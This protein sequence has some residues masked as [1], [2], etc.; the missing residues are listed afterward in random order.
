MQMCW[1]PI[2]C[3]GDA[4]WKRAKSWPESPG[5]SCPVGT[6]TI[7]WQGDATGAGTTISGAT[8]LNNTITVNNI[9]FTGTVD[10]SA[11]LTISTCTFADVLTCGYGT[12]L[13]WTN[14]TV[15]KKIVTNNGADLTWDNCNTSGTAKL[16]IQLGSKN[17]IQNSTV[18]VGNDPT[19]ITNISSTI[20]TGYTM[21]VATSA[22]GGDDTVADGLEM[23]SGSAT[24]TTANKLVD[25]GAN[26][27]S[28]M[29]NKTV[30][31]STNDTWAKITA[32][33]S[34]TQLSLSVDIMTSGD[35]Y[36]VA[37]AFSTRQAAINAIPGS[38]NANT[39][40]KISS[41][42]W[43]E[44][45][46]LIQ[47]KKATGTFGITIKGTLPTPDDTGTVTSVNG[48]SMGA[49]GSGAIQAAISDSTKAWTTNQHQ[50]K[51]LVLTGGTGA[52]DEYIIDSSTATVLTIAGVWYTQ[53]DTT[54]TYAIY[55]LGL[56]TNLDLSSL[57]GLE[58]HFELNGQIGVTLRHLKFKDWHGLYSVY[59][60]DFS[61]ISIYGCSF[62]RGRTDAGSDA[63]LQVESYATLPVID[64]TVF[65][66]TGGAVTRAI[67][68]QQAGAAIQG[69]NMHNIKTWGFIDSIVIAASSFQNWSPSGHGWVIRNPSAHGLNL[70]SFSRADLVSCILTGAGTNN[71][72]VADF[73]MLIL[74]T[75]CEISSA[76]SDGII[77]NGYGDLVNFWT[78]T[79]INSN[80]GWGINATNHSF[81]KNV[82][83]YS[84][85]G[86][87][88]GTYTADTS[89]ITT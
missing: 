73:G 86:N 11:V 53:P 68:L 41:G 88:S 1:V 84:Y 10:T 28:D 34:A 18:T 8:T 14:C 83:I 23:A 22:L 49:A 47:G 43:T 80:G 55:D 65:N 61:A 74:R 5:K 42:T 20:T 31:N 19:N 4:E 87:T 26:F 75:D 32:V 60:H 29:L 66:H 58:Q 17:L 78:S 37:N 54:T 81:G 36:V 57:A 71:V 89:S 48:Y 52:G 3:S 56:G 72:I 40:I 50:N 51:L 46:T 82:S 59:V 70:N 76:T 63:C 13:T 38:Y 15:S 16:F 6:K 45:N 30:W 27:T 21:Y 64:A 2:R 77:L 9:N 25:S 69:V 79:Q 35:S 33:D 7:T 44:A 12:L 24:S 39:T 62:E 67:R 85:A